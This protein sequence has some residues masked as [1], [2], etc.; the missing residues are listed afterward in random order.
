MKLTIGLYTEGLAF[1]GDT[2]YERA[3]GGS[4]TALSCM[5]R[6]LARRGHRVVVFCR[7]D[8]PGAYAGVLYHDLD[9]L[10]SVRRV[11]DF[12]VWIVSR[13]AQALAAAPNAGLRVL[14]NHDVLT[15]DVR[16]RVYGA[17]VWADLVLHLSEYHQRQWLDFLPEIA[18]LCRLTTNGVDLDYIDAAT[19]RTKKTPNV[20]LYSSRPERG[21]DVLVERIWPRILERMPEARLRVCG[22]EMDAGV[23]TP[24]HLKELYARIDRAIQ[25]TP[26]I[27]R[28]GALN[29]KALYREMAAARGLLYPTAFPEISCITASEAQAAG[30]PILTTDDFALRETVGPKDCLIGG[31]NQ[32]P[33]YHDAFVGRLF[34][35]LED[36]DKYGEAVERGRSH[37]EAAYQWKDVA[38]Q[39]E[40][41]FI[42]HLSARAAVRK[43]GVVRELVRRGDL[44]AAS[45]L[46]EGDD[47][48]IV[49]PRLA[50]AR[51]PESEDALFPANPDWAANDARCQLVRQVIEDFGRQTGGLSGKRLLDLGANNG[52]I[53]VMLGNAFPGLKVVGYDESNEACHLACEHAR[54]HLAEGAT[55]PEFITGTIREALAEQAPFDVVFSGELMEHV[56]DTSALLDALRNAATPGGLVVLTVPHHTK[57]VLWDGDPDPKR[58]KK[59]VPA[60]PAHFHAFDSGDLCD[61]LGDQRDFR[62]WRPPLQRNAAGEEYGNTIVAFR[63]SAVPFGAVDRERKRIVTRPYESLS[64]CM[65]TKDAENDLARCIVG[66]GSNTG[67]LGI[68]DEIRIHDTGST[69]ATRQI[70]R[71][72]SDRVTEA[73]FEDFGQA[74]NQSIEGALGDWVLW[75][76]ADEVL[77]GAGNLRRYLGSALFNGFAIRQNHL[78]IDVPGTH[79]K[80]IRLFRNGKGYRFTGLIHEHCE[81]VSVAPFDAPISPALELPD[82]DIAHTGYLCEPIRREKCLRNYPL[83]LKDAEA[84]PDRML[85]KV[86]LARDCLNFT[87]WDIEKVGGLTERAAAWC[88]QAVSIHREHFADPSHKYHEVSDGVYQRALELL[89]RAG[90][91]VCDRDAA[92]PFEV[93]LGLAAGYG[94]LR[95]SVKGA[96]RWFADKHEFMEHVARKTVAL[97]ARLA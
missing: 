29:K 13:F 58:P 38:A 22:Y 11:Y 49:R 78:M 52:A 32:D 83:V 71:R 18:P 33:A 14:W 50:G 39:W 35:F 45:S 27:E 69:D 44:V 34:D 12:D 76:D 90:V 95:R 88:R 70:A 9:A 51:K 73:A 60:H 59:R 74:R 64:V 57:Q 93:E 61:L 17:C 91:P 26:S 10:G 94:G 42:A 5:A 43:T 36:D 96:R 3:L 97:E 77:L 92:P 46:A 82:V 4:E 8:K 85:T 54:E 75:I 56:E 68:A 6:H 31:S 86:L 25:E 15:P 80:P 53:A 79:D 28:L 55:S 37:V 30:T 40:R 2:L 23:E 48:A 16:G 21:L 63:A 20:F 89:G 47:A 87:H 24:K 81:D 72:F 41:M 1:N 7:C 67:V 65:I 66:Q 84:H 19:R 62:L